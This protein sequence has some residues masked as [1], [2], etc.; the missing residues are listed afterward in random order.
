LAISLCKIFL[1]SR[2]HSPSGRDVN[3]ATEC[4]AKA[5]AKAK[6]RASKAKAKATNI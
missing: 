1:S 5:K 2:G 6:A 4:K 3:K